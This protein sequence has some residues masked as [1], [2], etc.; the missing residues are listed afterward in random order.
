[1]VQLYASNSKLQTDPIL[2]HTFDDEFLS[3][4]QVNTVVSTQHD[5]AGQ[6]IVNSANVWSQY[7]LSCAC[8]L[9]YLSLITVISGLILLNSGLNFGKR[10]S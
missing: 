2:K 5:T 6:V 1:M 7:V 10:K 8:L 3:C 4:I 9:C